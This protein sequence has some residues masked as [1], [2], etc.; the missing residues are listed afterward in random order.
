[1]S[2]ICRWPFYVKPVERCLVSGKIKR[3]KYRKERDS[4]NCSAC[5]QLFRH[6]MSVAGKHS[7]STLYSEA[8]RRLG[9]SARQGRSTYCKLVLHGNHAPHTLTHTTSPTTYTSPDCFC[10]INT[11]LRSDAMNSLFMVFPLSSSPLCSGI[12]VR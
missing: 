3:A 8:G 10:Q 2:I 1:M 6:K 11:L 9:E 12:C 4:K 5:G 7:Y